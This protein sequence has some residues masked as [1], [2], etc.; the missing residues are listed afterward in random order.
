MMHPKVEEL[1]TPV[2]EVQMVVAPIVVT[3][4]DMVAVT[5][6]AEEEIST[7]A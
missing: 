1:I 4:A 6:M 2:A 7:R 3:W 5:E